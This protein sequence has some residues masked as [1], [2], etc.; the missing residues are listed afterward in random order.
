MK[1]TIKLGLILL[2]IAAVSAGILAVTNNA[3]K[4]KIAEM[5][6]AGSVGA[7]EEIFGT[8]LEFKAVEKAELDAIM[9][10]NDDV[11]EIFQSLEGETVTGYAI[12][13]V[14]NGFG[15]EVTVLTGFNT[16]GQVVGLRV[17]ENSETAGIGSK[18]TEPDFVN[19]FNDLDATAEL[20][21][22]I[23]SGA[24]V[25]SNAV[26]KAANNARNVYSENFA[27]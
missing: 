11:K 16:E 19:Q 18:A 8:G 14:I 23:V 15:G 20:S 10:A 1:E 26:I 21:V 4:G 3:T 9:A 6:M 27:N 12:K 2:I 13:N 5:E 22:E 25:T 17:L 7:L 24:S